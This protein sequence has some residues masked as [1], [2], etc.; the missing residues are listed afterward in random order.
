LAELSDFESEPLA[1]VQ[2]FSYG[3]EIKSVHRLNLSYQESDI[4]NIKLLLNK[5]VG[6]VLGGHSGTVLAV[7]SNSE[8]DK[9]YYDLNESVAIL[10]SFYV[11]KNNSEGVKLCDAI[12][13]ATQSLLQK[14]ILELNENTGFSRF[15]P[16]KYH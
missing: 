1:V 9:I 8:A 5:R 12:N 10:D 6:G 7:N 3:A 14:S 11:C 16:K 15:N 13:K 2:A 4:I